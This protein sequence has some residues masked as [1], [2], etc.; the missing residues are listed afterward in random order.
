M[1][2]LQLFECLQEN[3]VLFLLKITIN[4]QNYTLY[5]INALSS[6]RVIRIYQFVKRQDYMT[7]SNREDS[8]DSRGITLEYDDLLL[9]TIKGRTIL[10]Y[11]GG[12]EFGNYPPSPPPVEI[13][14]GARTK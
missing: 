12:R 5:N 4:N 10:L 6:K 7:I 8:F 11:K 2:F 9:E 1:L 14:H 13:K 3:H